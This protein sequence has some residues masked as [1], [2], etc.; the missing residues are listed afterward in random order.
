MAVTI[1]GFRLMVVV[2]GG[3]A[4]SRQVVAYV[5]ILR[6]AMYVR[7]RRFEHL[8][9]VGYLVRLL[10][11]RR[12]SAPEGGHRRRN[13]RF[14]AHALAVAA[15]SAARTGQSA[16]PTSEPT[17]PAASTAAQAVV[18]RT[19]AWASVIWEKQTAAPLH[20]SG[21]ATVAE[22]TPRPVS[23]L[24]KVLLLAP[25]LVLL[26]LLSAKLLPVRAPVG[27]DPPP[28]RAELRR[29]EM[30]SALAALRAEIRELTEAQQRLGEQVEGL[31]HCKSRGLPLGDS[32]S[33]SKPVPAAN[34]R[35]EGVAKEASAGGGV[36]IEGAP[37]ARPRAALTTSHFQSCV[38]TPEPAAC[39]REHRP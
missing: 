35:T 7:A 32:L 18:P 36:P 2:L 16:S 29:A 37:G 28:R 13:A 26:V 5:R 12:P 22:N 20:N 8:P 9:L 15:R 6:F 23:A 14:D 10:A 19:L 33:D 4:L 27:G 30:R 21:A 3:V 25:L 34:G 17:A 31:V 11:P 39:E 24:R 38:G 1:L